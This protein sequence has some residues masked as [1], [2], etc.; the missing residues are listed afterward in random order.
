MPEVVE[1]SIRVMETPTAPQKHRDLEHQSMGISVT[2]KESQT[3][4]ETPTID[5][6]D[7]RSFYSRVVF[8]PCH[9]SLLE[10]SLEVSIM[11]TFHIY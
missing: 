6:A 4:D 10:A 2:Q 5:T 11:L 9:M 7:Q 3:W 8:A 1:P